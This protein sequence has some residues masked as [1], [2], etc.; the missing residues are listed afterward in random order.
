MKEQKLTELNTEELKQNEKTLK[1]ILIIFIGV[2]AFLIALIVYIIIK[3]GMTPLIAVPIALLPVL[4]VSYKKL[5]D[6]KSEIKS[7][8]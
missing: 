3:K 2:L 7:R 8:K 6:I 5:R 1:I 4:F